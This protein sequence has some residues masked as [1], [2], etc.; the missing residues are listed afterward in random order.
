MSDGRSEWVGGWHTVRHEV[1]W[2]ELDAAGHVN[3]A[4]YFTY[5]E[6]GRTKYWFGLHG[7]QEGPFSIGDLG[8]IVA[9]AECD[10][11]RQLSLGEAIEIR[12]RVGEVRRTSFDFHNQIVR[13]DGAVAAVGRVVVVRYS[14]SRGEKIAVEETLRE[15]IVAFQPM[16]SD[17]GRER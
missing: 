17:E 6:W 8:F 3:N 15:R 14:W 11:R 12:T 9:R 16:E 1:T 4:V 2:R 10:F 5:F 7:K 13:N